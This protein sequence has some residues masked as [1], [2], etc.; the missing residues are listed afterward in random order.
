MNHVS[1]AMRPTQTHFHLASAV[2]PRRAECRDILSANDVRV[3][4]VFSG[5]FAS[6]ED[7]DKAE[8]PVASAPELY[9]KLATAPEIVSGCNAEGLH[10]VDERSI[11]TA[12]SKAEG[13]S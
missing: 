4:E 2:G 13:R 5:A 7:T 11:R 9:A 10:I 6:L 8:F 3:A 12:L 1:I